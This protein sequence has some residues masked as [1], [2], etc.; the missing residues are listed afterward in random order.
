MGVCS[1]ANEDL[2]NV[3]EGLSDDLVKELFAHG[4]FLLLAEGWVVVVE[5]LL[6][7]ELIKYVLI[8]ELVHGSVGTMDEGLLVHLVGDGG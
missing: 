4:H 1:C 5:V 8:S 3:N 7:A 6:I 2:K